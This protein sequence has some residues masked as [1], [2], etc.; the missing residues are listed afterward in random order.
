MIVY[1]KY[2]PFFNVY[3]ANTW[4]NIL[5]KRR[6]KMKIVIV[7]ANSLWIIGSVLVL[8]AAGLASLIFHF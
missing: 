5:E 3:F 1:Y 7:P 2:A 4:Q 6:A 8:Q